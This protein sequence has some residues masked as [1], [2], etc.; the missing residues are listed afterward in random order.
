MPRAAV[1][2]AG[3]A[4]FETKP[5]DGRPLRLSDGTRGIGGLPFDERQTAL[6]TPCG[7]AL[8]AGWDGGRSAEPQTALCTP[9]GTAGGGSWDVGL[10]EAIGRLVGGEARRHGVDVVLGP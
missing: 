7:T 1:L 9:C 6:G 8:A 10:L 3:A 4:M 2:T 5:I